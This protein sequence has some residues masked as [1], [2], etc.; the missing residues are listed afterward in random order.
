MWDREKLTLACPGCRWRLGV[1]VE[2][3]SL[4]W[5]TTQEYDGDT[6][7]TE[8]RSTGEEHREKRRRERAEFARDVRKELKQLPVIDPPGPRSSRGWAGNEATG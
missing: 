5:W 1:P 7:S 2:F 6:N 8:A 3:V 4:G